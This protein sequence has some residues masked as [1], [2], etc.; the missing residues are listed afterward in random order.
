M[1]VVENIIRSMPALNDDQWDVV[2]SHGVILSCL[3]EAVR[4]DQHGVVN[5]V[6]KDASM[7]GHFF[8]RNELLEAGLPRITVDELEI[9]ATLEGD[10]DNVYQQLPRRIQRALERPVAGSQGTPIFELREAIRFASLFGV[11]SRTVFS[12]RLTAYHD[13]FREGVMFQ[14]SVRGKPNNVLASGGR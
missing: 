7:G 6:L 5:Q 2:F 14:V 1:A 10:L 12:P 9:I 11:S 3:Y 13:Y 4:D 8:D